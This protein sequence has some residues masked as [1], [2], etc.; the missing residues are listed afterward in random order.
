MPQYKYMNA[1]YQKAVGEFVERE[2][3]YNVSVIVSETAKHDEDFWHLFRAFDDD[4]AREMI[5]TVV[6]DDSAKKEILEDLDLCK[7]DDLKEALERLDLDAAQAE[8]EVYEHWIV[9]E[10]LADRLEAKGQSVERDFHGLTVW[11]RCC[12]GQAILLDSII[13]DIYD[14]TI[15]AGEPWRIE[16]I[17][18]LNDRIRGKVGLPQDKRTGEGLIVFTR[19]II[20]L[21]GPT[22]DEICSYVRAFDAFTEDNNP[23]RE[24][25][26]GSLEIDGV[27]N[28]FWKIDYYDSPK[29]EWGSED[30]ADPEQTFRVLTIMLA[31]EY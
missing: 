28:I 15:G 18:R 10:W 11:G 14:E 31:E 13:C 5:G 30:P 27:G 29:C 2:V 12:T 9:S 4:Q 26:F 6:G 19:G 20:D 7:T 24:R 23:H 16:T 8:C 3:I 25:D 21:P 1:E 17:A 22:Q